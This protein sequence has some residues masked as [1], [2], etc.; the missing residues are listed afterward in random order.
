MFFMFRSS[1]GWLGLCFCEVLCGVLFHSRFVVKPCLS[2]CSCVKYFASRLKGVIFEF[3]SGVFWIW[4][5]LTTRAY[6]LS[7]SINVGVTA[8]SISLHVFTFDCFCTL[9]WIALLCFRWNMPV[10]RILWLLPFYCAYCMLALLLGVASCMAPG[11]VRSCTVP[12][13]IFAVSA[14]E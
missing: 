1:H 14:L 11:H 7:Q 4:S 6:I 12:S 8:H 9:Y 2:C 13:M 5:G 10:V 3:S